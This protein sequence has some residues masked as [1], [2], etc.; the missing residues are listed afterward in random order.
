MRAWSGA[1]SASAMRADVRRGYTLIEVVAALA[2]AAIVVETGARLLDQ[3]DD[4]GRRIRRDAA[5]ATDDGTHRELLDA[6]LAHATPSSD[7]TRGFRG[8]E[9]AIE[10][11][12]RCATS[13]GW[14]LPCRTGLLIDSTRDSSIVF[15]RDSNGTLTSLRRQRGAASFLFLDP[16]RSDSMW[17]P[18]WH[19]SATLPAAIAIR[20]A[21][22]TLVIPVGAARD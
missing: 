22:D 4:E 18:R 5:I 12:T 15:A 10:Y 17:T 9:H 6:L 21:A 13:S 14:S 11:D 3:V 20:L 7:T 16:T 2:L 8:D 19:T 1:A